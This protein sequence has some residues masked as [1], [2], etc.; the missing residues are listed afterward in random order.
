MRGH[1]RFNVRTPLARAQPQRAFDRRG[2]KMEYKLVR[3]GFGAI[4]LGR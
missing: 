3:T 4:K 2:I 1:K